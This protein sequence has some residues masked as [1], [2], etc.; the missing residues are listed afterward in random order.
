M[1]HPQSRPDPIDTTHLLPFDRAILALINSDTPFTNMN[2]VAK[3]NDMTR[4]A[5]LPSGLPFEEENDCDV[6][7]YICIMAGIC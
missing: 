2:I 1:S 4:F 3:K 7:F 6:G 5:L